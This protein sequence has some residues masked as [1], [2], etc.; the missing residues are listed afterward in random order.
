MV[1]PA[2]LL[3][4]TRVQ[5]WRE[6]S[7]SHC[8]G[9]DGGLPD[10]HWILICRSPPLGGLDELRES[11]HGAASIQAGP[12]PYQTSTPTAPSHECAPSMLYPATETCPQSK[13]FARR[14]PGATNA[15]VACELY[16]D[17]HLIEPPHL[18]MRF[19][20]GAGTGNRLP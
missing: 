15:N 14:M 17:V 8:G 19:A 2:A 10:Q 18:P 6:K 4:R 11:S 16:A 1:P 12:L 20:P 13:K 5:N 9:K 3:H 7:E